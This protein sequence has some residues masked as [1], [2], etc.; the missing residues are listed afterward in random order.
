MTARKPLRPDLCVIGAGAAGLTVAAGAAQ[1]GASVALIEKGEMGG[2]CLNVGC[3]P[4]KA[5]LAAAAAAQ[6]AREAGRFGVGLPEPDINFPA[7]MA[8]V[9]DVIAGIAP[10][11]SVARFEGLGVTVLRSHAR[12]VDARTVETGDGQRIR[13]RR[14]VVATGSRPAIPPIRGLGNVPFLTNETV[15]A[16]TERPAHLLI[17]GGGPIG[18]ELSQAFRR[19]GSRVTMLARSR[20]LSRD[21]SELV[22]VVRDRLTAEGVDLREGGRVEAV[23]GAAGAVRLR[24][25]DANGATET[26]DG[27]HL[28]VATGR[29]PVTETLDLDA[30]G[31]AD[32]ARGITVDQGLRTTNRR[33]YAI[34]DVTGG[35]RF[36]HV[37]GYHGALV[38]KSALFRLPVKASA[39]PIPHV[40]YTDPELAAV[41]LS[42]AEARAAH[43]DDIR[44]LRGPFADNDRARCERATEG[45]LKVITDRKG[46]I[47]G[48]GVVGRHGGEGLAP[49]VLALHQRMKVGA[50]ATMVLPYPTR[51]EA[52]K[53]TAG[54]YFMPSLFSARARWLVRM[55][56]RLG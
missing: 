4:S 33:V 9:R 40:T 12:F 43:G 8:H 6:S 53:R 11:D 27:S 17:L 29:Q 21:D 35:P 44:V 36:T 22:A 38:I 39:T 7:V 42:E 19:L 5:M 26:L 15:F 51:S 46:R 14:F 30:A 25:A 32:T 45:L 52:A 55:L 48:A 28:L 10:M 37:A 2:D 54:S 50:L 31:I 16:L 24:I 13:A 56:A 47:L 3:V 49:W 18:C 34:G 23:E 20:I 41:G 1:M